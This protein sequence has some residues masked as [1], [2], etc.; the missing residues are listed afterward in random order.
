MSS[1]DL[2][3]GLW[4]PTELLLGSCLRSVEQKTTLE[5][6]FSGTRPQA[7]GLPGVISDTPHYGLQHSC[8]SRKDG[9]FCEAFREKALGRRYEQISGSR[10]ILHFHVMTGKHS[11][12]FKL[13]LLSAPRQAPTLVNEDLLQPVSSVHA[14]TQ[15]RTC[16]GKQ[17]GIRVLARL[18][19]GPTG[20]GQQGWTHQTARGLREG[21]PG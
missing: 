21:R 10:K 6:G 15:L 19:F 4:R 13:Q 18:C 2:Y 5:D 16:N 9:V 7:E 17:P 20:G 3:S 14:I 1:D 8:L 12:N 11:R